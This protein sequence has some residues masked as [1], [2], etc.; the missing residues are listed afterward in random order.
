MVDLPIEEANEFADDAL[1]ALLH[2]AERVLAR[3]DARVSVFPRG[4]FDEGP[5]EILLDVF[6]SFARNKVL[7]ISDAAHGSIV[8]TTT[9]LRSI[10]RLEADGFVYRSSDTSDKRRINLI[11]T[12]KGLQHCAVALRKMEEAEGKLESRMP[13]PDRER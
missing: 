5:W 1:F 8:S 4:Y 2:L 12:A 13:P 9:A 3:R 7:S 11:L 6:T 10:A